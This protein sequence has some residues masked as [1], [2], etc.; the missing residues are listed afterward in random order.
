MAMQLASL[1]A[2]AGSRPCAF[3]GLLCFVCCSTAPLRAAAEAWQPLVPV[4]YDRLGD[5]WCEV[6]IEWSAGAGRLDFL[7]LFFAQC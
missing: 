5:S 2:F 4:A 1:G 3:S 6:S 7:P